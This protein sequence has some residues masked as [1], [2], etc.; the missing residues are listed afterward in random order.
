MNETNKLTTTKANARAKIKSLRALRS[1][2]EDIQKQRKQKEKHLVEHSFCR[3]W[4]DRNNRHTF[5]T[6]TWWR[7]RLHSLFSLIHR[8]NS[9]LSIRLARLRTL[10]TYTQLYISLFVGSG[11]SIQIFVTIAMKYFNND[12]MHFSTFEL[13]Y[14]KYQTVWMYVLVGKVR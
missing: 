11:S 7:N 12:N 8:F 6:I 4:T 10:Y 9:P 13:D 3:C 14:Y 5:I 1:K 2:D